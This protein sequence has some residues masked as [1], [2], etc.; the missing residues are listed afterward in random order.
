LVPAH[1][2]VHSVSGPHWPTLLQVSSLIASVVQ[3]HQHELG[4]VQNEPGWLVFKQA[5]C[6]GV[7]AAPHWLAV[8][9]PLGL[10]GQ[11]PV[12]EQVSR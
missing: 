6:P 5:F 4:P 7:Q 3:T 8:T 10:V 11:R 1:L 12:A 2:P 9:V